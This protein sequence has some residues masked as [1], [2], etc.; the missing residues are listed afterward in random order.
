[1]RQLINALALLAVF[2]LTGTALGQYAPYPYGQSGYGEDANAL[3]T[4]WYQRYLGR[5]PDP[6]YAGWV[7]QLQ[8]GSAPVAPP[9][10]R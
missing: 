7:Q 9:K 5:P 6:G 4:S 8:M 1:M 3:V 2:S 10:K